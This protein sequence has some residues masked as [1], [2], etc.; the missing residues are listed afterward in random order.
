[1]LFLHFLL[2]AHSTISCESYFPR[3]LPVPSSAELRDLFLCS[4]SVLDFSCHIK[5]SIYRSSL[6]TQVTM[7]MLGIG[8]IGLHFPRPV[9]TAGTQLTLDIRTEKEPTDCLP[10]MAPSPLLPRG[11]Q[12]G[13]M[14]QVGSPD[15]HAFKCSFHTLLAV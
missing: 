11:F 5:L 6:P 12:R 4:H 2:L 3:A 8:G 7:S 15:G 14:V 9:H 13:D 10:S 1:M